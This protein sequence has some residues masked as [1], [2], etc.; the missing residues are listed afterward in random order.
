MYLDTNP[1]SFSLRELTEKINKCKIIF[2]EVNSDDII[3]TLNTVRDIVFKINKEELFREKNT[4]SKD[5]FHK[6]VSNSGQNIQDIF[7]SAAYH[8]ITKSDRP[9]T[10]EEF[11][12]VFNKKPDK[13]FDVKSIRILNDQ[14]RKKNFNSDEYYDFLISMKVHKDE[15]RISN[16]DFHKAI[17]KEKLGF[18]SEEIEALFQ[19]IDSKKD[20][21]IDRD[22]W[23][24]K[25][26][27]IHEPL[28]KITDLI[29]KNNLEIEDI[30]FRMQIDPK[31]NELLDFT[32]FKLSK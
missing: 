31:R 15:N 7:V 5:E 9:M 4:I 25:I 24:S 22:E 12:N 6:L 28:F 11:L 29:K 13:E 27:T 2:N 14:L 20:G 21:F 32:N 1:N 26:R 16:Y 30:M 10:K 19:N 8:S 23:N 3:S 18:S 17:G